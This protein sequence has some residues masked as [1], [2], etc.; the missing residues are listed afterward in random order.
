MKI[1][2]VYWIALGLVLALTVAV[3]DG[4]RLRDKYSIA[5]GQYQ[6]A[7]KSAKALNVEKDKAITDAQKMIT[8][9][10]AKIAELLGNA[11]KPSPSEVE[12]D[13]TIATL[14]KKNA[15]L[16]AAG[17][18]KAAYEGTQTEIRA[19]SDKFTFAEERHKTE[20]FDLNALWQGKF[21]AQVTISESWKAKYDAE[22]RIRTLAEKGWKASERKL[23]WTRI[24]GNLKTGLILAAVAAVGYEELKGKVK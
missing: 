7:L 12:K 23:K 1:K 22:C 19:W 5:V 10:T 14:K 20:L 11:G 18:Y 8:L 16:A 13:K 6:E 21:D 15:E 3:C 24:V 2:P 9:Q 17:D 4:L